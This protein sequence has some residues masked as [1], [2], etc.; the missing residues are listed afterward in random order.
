MRVTNGWYVDEGRVV[1]GLA[2]HN[3]IWGGY[4]ERDG[5]FA[6]CPIRPNIAARDPGRTG[7]G[8]TEDLDRLTD[9][10]VEHG[11]PGFEHCFGLWFDRRRDTHDTERRA[12]PDAVP[13]FLEQPW[14]RSGGGA[15][16]DGLPR[17]DLDRFNPY[18]FRRL[19]EF[20]DL[21]DRKGLVLFHDFY[22]QHALVEVEAHYVDFPWRPAN[23]LQPTGMPDR[24]P[25]ANAFYDVEHPVRGE[26]HRRYIRKCLDVLGD[27]RNVVHLLAEE[28][29]GPLSFVQFWLDEIRRW[30]EENGR[31]LHVG[32]GATKDVTDAVLDD[33]ARAGSISTIDLRYWSYD[34]SGSL[35]A[36]RG[37][38]QIP[39]RFMDGMR[40]T[41]SQLYRQVAEYRTRYPDRAL[42]I[43]RHLPS[44]QHVWAFLMGGGSMLIDKIHFPSDGSPKSL[45]PADYAAPVGSDIA[46]IPFRLVAEHLAAPLARAR[47]LP[48][49]DGQEHWCL[50]DPGR[51]YLVYLL[52]GGPLTVRLPPGVPAARCRWLDPRTGEVLEGGTPVTD[53]AGRVEVRAPDGQDWALWLVPHPVPSGP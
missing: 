9:A 8:H 6:D 14:P 30:E 26:L 4:R 21:C 52:R 39:A 1:W 15:A 10:M 16:W 32:L 41:P 20:A 25:A 34:A 31:C 49:G 36:P 45:P 43:E 23:C 2:Q 42:V 5:W 19:K 44:R 13:P 28:Y 35:D 24:V 7:P 17:Y 33:P 38:R 51:F 40:P 50:A 18:Y 46:R 27:N 12:D 53:P 3:G 47:P 37:G 11:V 48:L 29:T 22:L